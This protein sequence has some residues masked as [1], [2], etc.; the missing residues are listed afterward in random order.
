M[1]AIE[2][3]DTVN[4]RAALIT[5]FEDDA[6]LPQASSTVRFRATKTTS[7]VYEDTHGQF[8]IEDDYD[9]EGNRRAK[10]KRFETTNSNLMALRAMYTLVVLFFVSTHSFVCDFDFAFAEFVCERLLTPR[11]DGHSPS[12]VLNS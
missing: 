1:A 7:R 10:T 8:V 9:D 6:S 11:T 3:T 4:S 12:H 2:R 5:F